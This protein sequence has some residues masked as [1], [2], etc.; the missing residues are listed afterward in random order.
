MSREVLNYIGIVLCVFSVLLSIAGFFSTIQLFNKREDNK[1]LIY[2]I[3]IIFFLIIVLLVT[4][5][6]FLL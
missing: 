2:M 5:I 3:G 4:A 1:G 6:A